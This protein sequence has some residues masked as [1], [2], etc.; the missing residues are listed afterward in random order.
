M[1]SDLN[2]E[3]KYL[4]SDVDK[5][6]IQKY[7]KIDSSKIKWKYN[8]DEVARIKGF[9]MRQLSNYIKNNS[10]LFLKCAECNKLLKN[11]KFK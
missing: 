11:L 7:W 2:Y 1:N 3:I 8:I 5:E 4:N 10:E 9:N 6:I